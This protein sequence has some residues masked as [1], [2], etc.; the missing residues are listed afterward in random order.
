MTYGENKK[1]TL[2]LIEEYTPNMKAYTEYEDIATRLP[3]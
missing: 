3:F 1:I 2:A